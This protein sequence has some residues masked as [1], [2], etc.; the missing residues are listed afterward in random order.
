MYSAM[1]SSSSIKMLNVGLADP[2]HT[3]TLL[4]NAALLQ[5]R[6]T[7]LDFRQF[8]NGVQIMYMADTPNAIRTIEEQLYKNMPCQLIFHQ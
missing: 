2:Q 1:W 7:I 6:S 8:G 5:R 4:Q 3:G